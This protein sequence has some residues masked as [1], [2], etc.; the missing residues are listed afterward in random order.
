MRCLVLLFLASCA[1]VPPLPPEA[2][3]LTV[4]VSPER[5]RGLKQLSGNREHVERFLETWCAPV[6]R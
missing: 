2:D 5:C 3:T 6:T 4:A 1:S